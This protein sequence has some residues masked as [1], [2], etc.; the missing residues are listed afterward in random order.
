MTAKAFVLMPF[1]SPND[2][3]YQHVIRPAFQEF[4]LTCSRADE[5]RDLSEILADIIQGIDEADI[6]LAELTGQ[7]PNV[8]YELALAHAMNKPTIMICRGVDDVP[9]D[10]MVFRVI[11]Y[12]ETAKGLAYLQSQLRGIVTAFNMGQLT[13]ANPMSRMSGNPFLAVNRTPDILSLEARATTRVAVLAPNI[14]LGPTVFREVMRTNLMRGIQYQYILPDEQSIISAFHEF[15]DSLDLSDALGRFL[16]KVLDRDMI[17][18][19]VTLIDPGTP[20]E[21]GFIL[22]PAD[23]EFHFR[24]L[25]ESLYRLKERFNRLWFRARDVA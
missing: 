7:N 6:I 8:M 13:F 19:D 11:L 14:E 5:R 9:F 16:G 2:D 17:E 1:G 21:L 23:R 18:S 10:L 22:A 20:G 25:G 3:V 12:E 15:V 4:Y 24:V